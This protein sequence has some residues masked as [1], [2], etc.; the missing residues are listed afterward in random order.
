[1]AGGRNGSHWVRPSAGH[2]ESGIVLT[3]STVE[4]NDDKNVISKNRQSIQWII[5]K[6]PWCAHARLD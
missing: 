3:L 6:S 4:T 1:M 2:S 5:S